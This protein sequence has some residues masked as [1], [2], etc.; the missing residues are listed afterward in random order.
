M[1]PRHRGVGVLPRT[2]KLGGLAA[3]TVAALVASSFGGAALA[4]PAVS[5]TDDGAAQPAAIE[6]IN[7]AA[8]AEAGGQPAAAEPVGETA[9]AS[10]TSVRATPTDVVYPDIDSWIWSK[11]KPIATPDG[12]AAPEDAVGEAKWVLGFA[13][14]TV[15]VKSLENLDWDTNPLDVV[16]GDGAPMY[17][18]TM[19]IKIGG[20][21]LFGK[22]PVG[23]TYLFWHGGVWCT[24]YDHCKPLDE[25]IALN[26]D[27][28]DAWVGI[29][30][31]YPAVFKSMT[32]GDKKYIF[33]EEP[34]DL[35][36]GLEFVPAEVNVAAGAQGASALE[37]TFSR[38]VTNLDTCVFSVLPGDAKP[39]E[40][41]PVAYGP[42]HD[43]TPT[44]VD[45]D[46]VY[47][48][49]V[50]L[51]AGN[52]TGYL[53]CGGQ[54]KAEAKLTITEAPATLTSAAFD[55]D[56]VKVAIG[57]TATGH[58]VGMV[59]GFDPELYRVLVNLYAL[60]ED[61]KLVPGG[62][63]GSG[64]LSADAFDED[65][66]F[67]ADFTDLAPGKYKA[68]VALG[69]LNSDGPV[70]EVL[71]A[72]LEVVEVKAAFTSVAF[73]PDSIKVAIGE[74]ATGHLVGTVDGFDP[75]LYRLRVN[76]YAADED[77]KPVGGV[78]SGRWVS[79]DAFAE[80]GSF[81]TDFVDLAP[82][83]YAAKANV[84]TVSAGKIVGKTLVAPLEIIEIK[85]ELTSA[86]FDPDE[87]FVRGIAA[88]GTGHLVGHVENFDDSLH[89]SVALY[90]ADEDGNLIQPAI[91]NVAK[92]AV[93]EDGNF[94]YNFASLKAG[95][96]VADVRLFNA[97]NERIGD[98]IK[99]P[100]TVKTAEMITSAAFVPDVVEVSVG[101][102][103][104]GHLTG[105]ATDEV[106]NVTYKLRAD[107]YQVDS[108]GNIIHPALKNQWLT[109]EDGEYSHDFADLAAGKYVAKVGVFTPGVAG[110]W[111][112]QV[113]AGLTVVEVATEVT[114]EAP[115]LVPA[116]ECGVEP[117]VTIPEMDGV[118]YT[119][120]RDGD[121]VTVT[122][123]ATEGYVIPEGATIE[124]TFNVAAEPCV[125]E[126]TGVWF[127]P[128]LVEVEAG[129][130]ALVTCMAPLTISMLTGTTS[131]RTC[132][133]PMRMASVLVA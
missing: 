133:R 65:G 79:A 89:V 86:A 69:A 78:L 18:P 116:T 71:A 66:A 114:P 104:V 12:W 127:D 110:G 54:F 61:G 99:A 46:Y 57:E 108:E 82:G 64:W 27:E 58:L 101:G 23:G 113:D 2:K 131:S 118:E 37:A 55:P 100:L 90:A 122:A 7:E 93:D 60:D 49:P 92:V 3:A 4:A 126:L 39:G 129:I 16:D 109:V 96:Y 53:Y 30:G 38:E 75:E 43:M 21:F 62:L 105:T 29:N 51:D 123:S 11:G 6:E 34:V 67:V 15:P 68:K 107:L 115:V 25:W 128:A 63:P 121:T 70:G 35:V 52:Y 31:E 103:G 95:K 111:L 97:A 84:S 125:A 56:L 102:V 50:S 17:G 33:S 120:S 85:A 112:Q 40:A 9:Q 42:I 94:S 10:R 36:K 76:L 45:G 98:A 26:P 119:S 132:T 73:D 22:I 48:L 8:T 72:D 106:D 24:D 20:S 87:V 81:A 83:K 88:V 117:T 28:E 77:G 19:K 14:E 74:T 44:E 5:S 124:W 47:S 80:D 91:K 13:R 41:T 130:W 32:F 59:D 1:K